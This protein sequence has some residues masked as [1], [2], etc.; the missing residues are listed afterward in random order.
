MKKKSTQSIFFSLHSEYEQRLQ[1]KIFVTLK[2]ELKLIYDQI[3]LHLSWVFLLV[4]IKH[5]DSKKDTL[6]GSICWKIKR[7][8]RFYLSSKQ[9]STFRI[10]VTECRSFKILL[11]HLFRFHVKVFVLLGSSKEI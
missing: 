11:Q 10:S 3:L 5:D 9:T 2:E 8:F 7:L 4:G 6:L 1:F